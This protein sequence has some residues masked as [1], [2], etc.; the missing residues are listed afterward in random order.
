MQ[1]LVYWGPRGLAHGVAF[2][3]LH[4]GETGTPQAAL[5]SKVLAP[6]SAIHKKTPY[7]KVCGVFFVYNR[8]IS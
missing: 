8:H 7:T 3:S 4:P 5:R 1:K 2:K 6:L